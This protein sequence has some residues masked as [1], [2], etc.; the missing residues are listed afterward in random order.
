M[1][2]IETQVEVTLTIRELR[3]QAGLSQKEAAEK[4][5]VSQATYNR[6]EI[7]DACNATLKTL[8]KIDRIFNKRLKVAFK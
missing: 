5:G 2:I 4:L 3:K 1:D 8:D 6:W 7:P